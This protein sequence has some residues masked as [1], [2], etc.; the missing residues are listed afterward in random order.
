MTFDAPLGSQ[1]GGNVTAIFDTVDGPSG[2]GAWESETSTQIRINVGSVLSVGGTWEI[3][4]LDD[5]VTPAG[6]S[7]T[8]P[9]SGTI[10]A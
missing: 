3:D 5:F 1:P 6:Y 7:F 2:A 8:L 10:T 4:A 9:Q